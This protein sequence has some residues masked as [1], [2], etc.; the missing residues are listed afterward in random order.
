M[1]VL[2]QYRRYA[3]INIYLLFLKTLHD[4]FYFIFIS[5]VEIQP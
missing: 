2:T 1:D 3:E 5:V 4:F